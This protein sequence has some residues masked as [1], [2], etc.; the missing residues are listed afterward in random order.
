MDAIKLNDEYQ[1]VINIIKTSIHSPQLE[2]CFNLIEQFNIQHPTAQCM[3]ECLTALLHQRIQIING[4][5]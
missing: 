5:Q 3:R 1:W 2:I 4:D